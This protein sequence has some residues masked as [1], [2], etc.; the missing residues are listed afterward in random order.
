MPVNRDDG[1]DRGT[2][3]VFK[4]VVQGA[5]GDDGN[6]YQVAISTDP[7]NNFAVA[8]SRVFA[9]SASKAAV[10]ALT[11]SLAEELSASSIWINAIVPSIIDTKANRAAMPD[12]D[13]SAWPKPD[14]IAE[15]VAFL[16]SPQ[17]SVVRGALVPVYGKS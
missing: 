7:N 9:Y 5:A 16:A 6:W 2:S 11:L 1:E 10:A 4:L 15:T 17:N 3:R 8:G 13:H 12:A 14:E